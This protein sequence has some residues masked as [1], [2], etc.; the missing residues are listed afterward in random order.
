MRF[1]IRYVA[2]LSTLVIIFGSVLPVPTSLG[3]E[4][5]NSVAHVLSYAVCSFSWTRS[6]TSKKRYL[7][8]M[9]AL[10]PLTEVLQLPLP[11]RHP[12]VDDLVANVF[13][14]ILGLLI[15]H[16]QQYVVKNLSS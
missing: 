13:G 11:Y 15:S 9:A 16:V 7:A 3:G 8:L 5:V 12:C 2:F 4:E 1:D 6:L 14:I 10:T